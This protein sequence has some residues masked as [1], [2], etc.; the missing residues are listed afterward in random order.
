MSAQKSYKGV[1]R[2]KFNEPFKAIPK[3]PNLIF[4]QIL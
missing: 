4:E 1:N 3:Q 2:N